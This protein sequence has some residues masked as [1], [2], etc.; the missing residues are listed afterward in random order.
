[1]YLQFPNN[2]IPSVNLFQTFLLCSLINEGYNLLQVLE[3]LVRV[4]KINKVSTSFLVGRW[5][6]GN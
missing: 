6:V 4:F 2:M 5:K 3:F 1:M